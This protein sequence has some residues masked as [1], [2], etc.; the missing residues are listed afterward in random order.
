MR[1]S[2]HT[3]RS[4]HGA[5]CQRAFAPLARST[6]ASSAPGAARAPPPP[7]GAA[8]PPAHR[9]ALSARLFPAG[10][11]PYRIR[12]ALQPKLPIPALQGGISLL[13]LRRARPRPGAPMVLWLTRA[14]RLF[15]S[16]HPGCAVQTS[17]ISRGNAPRLTKSVPPN[18]EGET[19]R[20]GPTWADAWRTG[21]GGAVVVWALVAPIR[22]GEIGG[23][24][25]CG[26]THG[27]DVDGVCPAVG[28]RAEVRGVVAGRHAERHRDRILDR[29][30]SPQLSSLLPSSLKLSDTHSLCALNTSPPRNR[31]TFP[32][33]YSEPMACMFC[34]PA[35][36]PDAQCSNSPRRND[37]MRIP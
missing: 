7:P 26:C 23:G 36:D 5:T 4:L 34:E 8:L 6:E 15:T 21:W 11:R 28:E 27:L 19:E 18:I 33:P 30:F 22:C 16:R 31:C 9:A 3:D 37:L 17:H 20:G 13:G 24:L 32:P 10:A 1:P 35:S 12:G 29:R 14:D 25:G 2:V